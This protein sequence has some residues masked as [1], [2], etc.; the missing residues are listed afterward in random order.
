MTSKS[1]KEKFEN[2]F[3]SEELWL[4]K[5]LFR[6]QEKKFDFSSQAKEE[7][8][9]NYAFR[10]GLGQ[11]LYKSK[12]SRFF[13]EKYQEVLYNGYLS[14]LARNTNLLLIADEISGRLKNE[15][16]IDSILLKGSFLAKHIYN[17]SALRPMSDIDILLPSDQAVEAWKLLGGSS[18]LT[19][20]DKDFWSQHLPPIIYRGVSIEIHHS[21]F[22]TGHRYNI[23]IPLIWDN[24]SPLAQSNILVLDP[25]HQLLYLSLHC[26]YTYRTGGIRLG[27]FIDIEKV[28]IHYKN[29]IGQEALDQQIKSLNLS[30]PL[31]IIWSMLKV[32]NP[33]NQLTIPGKKKYDKDI[34]RMISFFRVSDNKNFSG[35]SLALERMIFGRKWSS[36]LPLL[37]EL[38]LYDTE[39][40]KISLF[41]RLRHLIKNSVKQF[42]EKFKQ[43]KDTN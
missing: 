32:L 43:R 6:G 28:L 39:G 20:R 26:Y 9:I 5:V 17:D 10:N 42:T 13:S 2:L 21:L 7:Y 37:K 30:K 23:P 40:N 19:S 34:K 1:D 22:S 29:E 12:T 16:G 18:K 11:L 33:E 4:I 25:I 31:S 38:I 3:S 41:K 8:I 27:W 14:G 35:Y 36:K 24:V 15:V